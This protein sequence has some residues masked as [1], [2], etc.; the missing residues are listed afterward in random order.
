MPQGPAAG[1]QKMSTRKV[2]ARSLESVWKTS[3]GG[4]ACQNELW[5]V[6]SIKGTAFR[7]AMGSWRPFSQPVAPAYCFPRFA[8]DVCVL[9]SWKA[10]LLTLLGLSCVW[11]PNCFHVPAHLLFS[12]AWLCGFGSRF[13]T[14]H[15]TQA[16]ERKEKSRAPR[17]FGKCAAAAQTWATKG[18]PSFCAFPFAKV[19]WGFMFESCG[20]CPVWGGWPVPEAVRANLQPWGWDVQVGQPYVHLWFL[21]GICR[22][23]VLLPARP[24]ILLALHSRQQKATAMFLNW[25]LSDC[26]THSG[27]ID[28]FSLMRRWCSRWKPG[29]SILGLSKWDAGYAVFRLWENPK[30]PHGHKVGPSTLAWVMNNRDKPTKG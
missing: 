11:T 6:H 13:G 19:C 17:N 10:A 27:V 1:Q 8:A 4:V 3:Q 18:P 25:E 5:H 12:R 20:I 22:E 2:R 23:D 21:R 16:S 30:R 24:E 26:I 7:N 28:V 29:V 9:E 14:A 15:P